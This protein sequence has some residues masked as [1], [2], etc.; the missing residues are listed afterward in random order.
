MKIS[1]SQ[2]PH[3]PRHLVRHQCPCPPRHLQHQLTMSC[4]R[5]RE[6]LPSRHQPQRMSQPNY[7]SAQGISNCRACF[8]DAAQPQQVLNSRSYKP[9]HRS[10]MPPEH[11][12]SQCSTCAFDMRTSPL[13]IVDTQR[14]PPAHTAV[15]H[16]LFHIAHTH[17]STLSSTAISRR[18][19]ILS[20][21]R[22]GTTLTAYKAT[23]MTLKPHV[24]APRSRFTFHQQPPAAT[25]ILPT[26][27]S[28][29]SKLQAPSAF[30][31][32]TTS[33]AMHST[34]KSG[35]TAR[36]SASSTF[37]RNLRDLTWLTWYDHNVAR[38]SSDPKVFAF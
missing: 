28:S 2:C 38:L 22:Q 5:P 10:I 13:R 12:A 11:K 27:H 29:C 37:S 23:R 3:L 31:P 33:S 20:H 30:H 25:C 4:H 26:R 15:Q 18:S 19:G 34:R 36:S 21:R 35:P 24:T 14:P 1:K 8:Q 6:L 17:R 16:F 32:G 7:K 9:K